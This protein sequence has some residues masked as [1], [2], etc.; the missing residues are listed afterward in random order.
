MFW[1]NTV[2]FMVVLLFLIIALRKL[3]KEYKESRTIYE[4]ILFWLGVLLVVIPLILY[5]LDYFNIASIFKWV[6]SETSDRWFNYISSYFSSFVGA[7]IGAVV[8]VLTTAKQINIQREKDIDDRRIQNMPLLMY[9]ISEKRKE[10]YSEVFL[11]NLNGETT[12]NLYINVNNVGLN[13]A[14]NVFYAIYDNKRKIYKSTL[15]FN[16]SIIKKDDSIGMNFIF[17]YDYDKNKK[18]NKKNITIIWSYE[19]LLGNKYSQNIDI[20]LEITNISGSEYGGYAFCINKI[21]IEKEKL[22]KDTNNTKIIN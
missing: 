16:Q 7:V 1:M 20:K 10:N 12:Y 21:T 6:N 3:Y 5:Y 19:D 8:V 22:I 4:K 17:N 11:Y 2:S 18:N 9:D 15:D 13:L 14:R